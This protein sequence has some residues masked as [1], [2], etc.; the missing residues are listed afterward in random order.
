MGDRSKD[1]RGTVKDVDAEVA[2][3]FVIDTHRYC[4]ARIVANRDR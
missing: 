4:S 3:D 1:W 2:I